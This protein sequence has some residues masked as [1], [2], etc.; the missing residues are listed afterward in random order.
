MTSQHLGYR[1]INKK[2]KYGGNL[3]AT[4]AY[5]SRTKVFEEITHRTHYPHAKKSD[6]ALAPYM[7]L[8]P[9]APESYKD[10]TKCFNAINNIEKGRIAYNILIPFQKELPFSQNL[11]LV[12]ELIEKEFVS[13]GH[14]AHIS[15]HREKDGNHNYHAHIIVIDRRLV[16]DKWEN[17]K[18]ETAY[19]LRGTVK[20]LSENGKVINPDAVLLT[21]KD[22]IDT[23]KLKNK[24]LQYDKDG[25]II[26]K[27]GWQQLQYDENGKPLLDEK[28][29][30]VMIDIR[31]PDRGKSLTGP[32]RISK[33]KKQ[34]SDAQWKRTT[35]KHSDIA[36]INNRPK[37]RKKWEIIQN[38][39]FKKYNVRDKNGEILQVDLRSYADQNKERPEDEHLTPTVRT[40]HANHD[41]SLKDI[42]KELEE[43]NK[44]AKIRNDNVRLLQSEKRKLLKLQKDRYAL[45][46]KSATGDAGDINF[47]N[48]CN[49]RKTYISDYEKSYKDMLRRQK[50]FFKIFERHLS[51]NLII[52][53]NNLAKTDSS[54]QRG[55]EK[56]TYLRRHQFSIQSLQRKLSG[57]ITFGGLNIK[58]KAAKIFD[59]FSNKDI[60][61]YMGKRFGEDTIPI[62]ANALKQIQ[63]DNTNPFE[64][65]SKD[66]P[67][68]PTA[69]TN[70]YRLEASSKKITGN[71]NFAKMQ[72][73]A[74]DEW[75][76]NP[77]QTAPL[78]VR[79]M[80]NVYLTAAESYD[81]HLSNNKKWRVVTFDKSTMNEAETIN[82]QYQAELQKIADKES[83]EK[84]ELQKAE[85]LRKASEEQ[86][87]PTPEEHKEIH[88][89][90][91]EEKDDILN[92]MISIANKY[93]DIDINTIVYK[94][95]KNAGKPYRASQMERIRNMI[96]S[97][98][99][100]KGTG[101]NDLLSQWKQKDE[102]TNI[103]FHKYIKQDYDSWIQD[104]SQKKPANLSPDTRNTQNTV[105][106]R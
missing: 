95:G 91:G 74:F 77:G 101:I 25:N 23:P 5:N 36:C 14:P 53:E 87:E 2:K 6:L 100:P 24:R 59:S 18:S 19:Y 43:Y 76:Q 73:E 56:R 20:E 71:K 90:M 68:F 17:Q 48:Y 30:P 83:E 69:D 67:V 26:F 88:K 84:L 49:P 51:E 85:S 3:F 80:A 13:K 65:T 35:I 8:P 55:I 93:S 54:S 106:T 7:L 104:K 70:K 39:Y 9:H 81:A 37:F 66:S 99:I 15:I 29:Y 89:R 98:R 31:E 97:N 105:R 78:S 38:E 27:K 10:A 94:S 64:A 52:N 50:K 32:Q 11:A 33:K 75:E 41:E 82:Q 61:S 45:N 63:P 96:K 72:K 21:E 44:N 102:E 92:E 46:N 28:G 42:L 16:N 4:L 58:D 34:Y 86:H 103:Y 47:Y 22:K 12:N 57:I 79:K 40:F 60:A 62:V 1:T